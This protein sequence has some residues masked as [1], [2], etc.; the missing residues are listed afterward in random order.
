M[1]F[2][3]IKKR[4]K[5]LENN[6]GDTTTFS[7]LIDEKAEDKSLISTLKGTEKDFKKAFSLFLIVKAEDNIRKVN[8]INDG[9]R[10]IIKTIL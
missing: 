5:S 6:I 8:S 1:N 2:A 9:K 7:Y 3:D 10:G 4:D